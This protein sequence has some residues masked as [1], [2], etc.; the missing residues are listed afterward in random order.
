VTSRLATDA[1]VTTWREE[2]WVLLEGLVGTEV[3]DALVDDLGHI[4][5]SA[6]E[7]Q[8]DPEGVHE[9]WRGRPKQ[10]EGVSSGPT[11]GPASVRPSSVGWPPSP[12]RAAAR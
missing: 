3:I 4:F 10:P 12:S 6:E 1:E 2:G 7:H 9:Q 5:P 11:R 8:A